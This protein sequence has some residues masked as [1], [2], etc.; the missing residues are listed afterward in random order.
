MAINSFAF[1]K[2]SHEKTIQKNMARMEKLLKECRDIPT[3]V[4]LEFPKVREKLPPQYKE[5]ETL[6]SKSS[7][8]QL[9]EPKIY[10]HKI[11]LTNGERPPIEPLRTQPTEQLRETK[12]YIINNLHKG[13]IE[14]SY[15]P[16]AAPI[17]FVKKPD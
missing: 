14:S 15:G 3:G 4:K 7:S 16:N 9:P 17:L 13:F 11:E 5:F 6:F 1:A 8:D 10:D 12:R 2:A